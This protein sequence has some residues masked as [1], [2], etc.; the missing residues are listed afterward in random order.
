MSKDKKKPK[1][2]ATAPV[3]VDP[4]LPAGPGEEQTDGHIEGHIVTQDPQ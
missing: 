1:D 4:S 3:I 2:D